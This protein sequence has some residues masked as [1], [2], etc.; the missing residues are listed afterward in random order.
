MSAAIM[1]FDPSR[2]QNAEEKYIPSSLMML[3]ATLKKQIQRQFVVAVL[4]D[5]QRD[6]NH[7]RGGCHCPELQARLVS[8]HVWFF[9]PDT[10][11]SRLWYI[12]SNS[13]RVVG[14]EAAHYSVDETTTQPPPHSVDR[15]SARKGKQTDGGRPIGSNG[16]AFERLVVVVVVW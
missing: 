7:H 1:V 11:I 12:D 15:S 5:L 10:A 13:S 2:M 8:R 14:I 6:P 3:P 9:L 16:S 4:C